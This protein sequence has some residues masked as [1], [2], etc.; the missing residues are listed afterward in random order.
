[1][2]NYR[3]DIVDIELESGS[4]HRE[5]LCHSIGLGDIKANRFGVRLF[6]G[7]EPEAVTGTCQGFLMRPGRTNLQ[8][9]GSTY[10]SVSGNTAYVILP[11]DA[12]A[13]EGQFSLAIKLIGGG[14]TG[15]IRIID[16]IIDNTGTTGAVSPSS[17]VP[18]STEI[19]AAYNEAVDVIE[20][21]VRFDTT[22]SLTAAQ[23]ATAQSN[24]GIVLSTPSGTRSYME[25]T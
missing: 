7:G 5:W 17:E 1:M 6:R 11:Q 23:Q 10:T 22:Q 25:S 19:I 20:G 16:G 4:I 2:A 21:S 13:Y 18:T 15:T 8:I 14:V 9:Q 3:E 12:Y 24:M